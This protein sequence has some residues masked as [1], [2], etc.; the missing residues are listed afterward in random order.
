MKF[1]VIVRK[2]TSY[3]GAEFI[4]LRF[5]YF[6][7]SQDLLEEVICGKSEERG[8]PFRV[9][10]VGYLRPG[11]FLKTLSFQ[12]N[13]LAFLRK[14]PLAINFTFSKVPECDVY[15]NGGGVHF[16]FLK[17]SLNAYSSWKIFL[18]AVSRAL[19][20]VNYFNPFIER[21]IFKTSGR[22]IA[23]SSLVKEDL[24]SYCSSFDI[25]AKIE[26][27]PNPVDVKRFSKKRRKELRSK[28]REFV[29]AGDKEYVVG[30]ASSNFR[31]KGLHLLI[32]ALSYLPEK[33]R[34]VVAGGRNPKE[35][36]RLAEK[37]G[38]RNRVVFLGKVKEMELFYSGID[39]LAHPSYYDTFGNVVAEALSMGVPVICSKR[40]GAKDFVEEGKS[41]FVL[42]TFSPKEIAEK[43][44]ASVNRNW[45]FEA[46]LP[47]DEEV[48][49]RYVEIGEQSL[50]QG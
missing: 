12:R 7:H 16:S 41:G 27:V 4:A 39:L 23:V 35:F 9:R 26:V 40:T 22:I 14:A 36:I 6:L 43:V 29:K 44:I 13:V 15:V 10:E 30:F 34:L 47:S 31:L 33:I 2:F 3:G 45:D 46:N 1:R 48:F 38:V 24:L 37:F 19:N 42:K 11:R 21:K 50:R 18:K 28:G 5:A 25:R 17:Y 8:V 49:R 20:P 32:E